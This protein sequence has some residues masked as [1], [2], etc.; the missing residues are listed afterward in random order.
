MESITLKV[1]PALARAMAQAM[2]P[3][4]STKTEFIREASRDKILA[5]EKEE[6]LRN[7]EKY[8]GAGAHH[9]TSAADDRKAREAV[10]REI[11]KEFG[12]E[13]K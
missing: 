10:G 11:A 12:I 4:Y 1:D 5:R 7:L 9:K 3:H 13:L 2:R 6:A 8:L